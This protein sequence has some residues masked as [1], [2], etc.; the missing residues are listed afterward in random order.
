MPIRVPPGGFLG[1]GQQNLANQQLMRQWLGNGS[2]NGTRRRR[3]RKAVK[4]AVRRV[5]KRAKSTVKARMVKGSAAAK[6]YMAKI[7]RKRKK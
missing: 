6:A 1:A 7:R 4:T 5:A 3:R 2:G